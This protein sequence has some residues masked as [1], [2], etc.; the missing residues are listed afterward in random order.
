MAPGLTAQHWVSGL[1]PAPPGPAENLLLCD[2]CF[3]AA[4]SGAAMIT[5]SEVSGLNTA[6]YRQTVADKFAAD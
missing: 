2:G 6:S 4:A 5:V 1:Y 3:Q